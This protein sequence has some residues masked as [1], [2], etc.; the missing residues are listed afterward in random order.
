MKYTFRVQLSR[1]E[2]W[3]WAVFD[4]A[5]A[6]GFGAGETTKLAAIESIRAWLREALGHAAEMECE[7][8][9]RKLYRAFA[10]GHGFWC[11]VSEFKIVEAKRS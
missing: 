11:P 3:A 10:P 7:C 1:D 2:T 9:S 6:R 5:S 8:G 4:G